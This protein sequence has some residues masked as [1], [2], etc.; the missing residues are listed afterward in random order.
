M[1]KSTYNKFLDDLQ[2]YF[3]MQLGNKAMIDQNKYEYL[4]GTEFEVPEIRAQYFYIHEKPPGYKIDFPNPRY[5][6]IMMRVDP[7][8]NKASLLC[9]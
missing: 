1:G 2:I 4:K 9:C 3:D 8:A 5:Y 7:C 6:R